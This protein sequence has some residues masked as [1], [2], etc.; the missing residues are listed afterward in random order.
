MGIFICFLG[1]GSIL[2]AEK[3]LKA[4]SAPTKTE[5]VA[6][7]K[8]A[9]PVK[10]ETSAKSGA[11]NESAPPATPA[12]STVQAPPAVP[13]EAVSEKPAKI[14]KPTAPSAKVAS[15]K[16]KTPTQGSKSTMKLGEAKKPARKTSKALTDWL[17]KMK[18]RID[19]TK[20]KHNKIVAVAS[21]RGAA[22]KD[23]LPLYWKGKGKETQISAEELQ[24]FEDAVALASEGKYSEAKPGLENFMS[25]YPQSPLITE[26]KET[27]ALLP[28]TT[29]P[30]AESAPAESVP[31]PAPAV[32]TPAPPTTEAAK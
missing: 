27:L 18:T 29:P 20:S 14:E 32:S 13:V 12:A 5:T 31:D 21:V 23:P 22:D 3:A 25:A 10:T 4:E 2:Q 15:P 28:D 19:R 1:F 16:Q 9:A 6:A 7:A 8:E 26:A 17:N 30:P 24:K 11:V